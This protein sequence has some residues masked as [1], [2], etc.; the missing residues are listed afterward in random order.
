MGR[1]EELALLR[2]AWHRADSGLPTV[3]VVEGEAGIGKTRLVRELANEIGAADDTCLIATGHGVDLTVGAIPYGLAASLFQ[4]LAM[5]VGEESLESLLGA[6]APAL[7]PLL[8]GSPSTSDGAVLDR[9]AMFGAVQHLLAALSR[10]RLVCL[11]LED[12]HWA[13]ASSLDLVVFLARTARRGRLL[14]VATVRAVA[15]LDAAVAHQVANLTRSSAAVTMVLSPLGPDDIAAQARDALNGT[16]ASGD[17]MRQVVSLSDGIPL[18]VEEILAATV[19]NGIAPSGTAKLPATLAVSLTA[20]VE[21]LS[22]AGTAVLQ[23]ASVEERPFRV[24]RL[25]DV[26]GQSRQE[27]DAALTEATAAGV[28]D[29]LTPGRYRFHHA[30]LRRAVSDSLPAPTRTSWHRRWAEVLDADVEDDRHP[31]Q[32]GLVS[33]VA[34]HWYLAAEPD[35]AFES[36]LRAARAAAML[37]APQERAVHLRRALDLWDRTALP[38]ETA[39]MDRNTL[40]ALLAEALADADEYEL[41]RDLIDQEERRNTHPTQVEQLWYRYERW[42]TSFILG[43][44]APFPLEPHDLPIVAEE[45]ASQPPTR[46]LFEVFAALFGHAD[47]LGLEVARYADLAEHT[48]GEIEHDGGLAM[49]LLLRS[50]FENCR[51]HYEDAAELARQVIE[52]AERQPKEYYGAAR[53]LALA[54]WALGRYVE[55]AELGDQF[56]AKIG[57]PLAAPWWWSRLVTITAET[58]RLL[59]DYARVHELYLSLPDLS[60]LASAAGAAARARVSAVC[61]DF[62]LAASLAAESSKGTPPIGTEGSSLDWTGLPA[63]AMATL[64]LERGTYGEARAVLRPILEADNLTHQ[65]NLIWGYVLTAARALGGPVTEEEVSRVR[66]AAASLSHAGPVGHAW[67]TEVDAHLAVAEG[68]DPVA[69]FGEAAKAWGRLSV[70]YDEAWCRLSLADAVLARD[71]GTA[72]ERH[73]VASS[74]LGRAWAL[75]DRIGARPLADRVQALAGRARVDLPGHRPRTSGAILTDRE[76]EVLQLVVRGATNDQ[77]GTALFMSPRTASV[78]VSHILAKLGA[79]NRTEVAGLAHRMG[80][81]E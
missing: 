6:R 3:A 4:D 30:L 69:L 21:G 39:G 64:A 14:V 77:I 80:L 10:E 44:P 74:E 34:H 35:H 25:I 5:E 2:E 50:D 1:G 29:E 32:F 45:L 55:A 51:H 48:A 54:L 15:G 19:G 47:A 28:L 8:G 13:D 22:P 56:L 37:H 18:Y 66:R 17:L 81:V 68:A 42:N 16:R 23:A 59:G 73:A 26:T 67:A 46:M 12:L 76:A 58:H 31:S 40:V 7:A 78:H 60:P 72:S 79:A 62:E 27:L 38:D 24:T 36:A 52:T 9:L 70:P 33:A 43:E 75:A 20:R 63:W 11:F 61:G 53:E 65:G 71:I 41:R 49:V 57:S